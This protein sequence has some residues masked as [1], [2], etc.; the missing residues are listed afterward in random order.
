MMSKGVAPATIARFA[1]IIG[2]ETA[3]QILYYLDEPL[4]LSWNDNEGNEIAWRLY[5]VD[6]DSEEANEPMSP[7]E[8]LLSADPTGREMRPGDV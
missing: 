5:R 7:M 2:Y 1:R 6:P 8:F 4:G 3:H